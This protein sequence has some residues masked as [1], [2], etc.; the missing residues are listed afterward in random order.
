[1][2]SYPTKSPMVVTDGHGQGGSCQVLC[3]FLVGSVQLRISFL[4]SGNVSL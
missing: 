4:S 3:T 1:M 2:H